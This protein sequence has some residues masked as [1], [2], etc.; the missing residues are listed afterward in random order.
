MMC[1]D[2]RDGR[3]RFL[4]LLCNCLVTFGSYYCFDMPGVLQAQFQG[5]L[6][7]SDEQNAKNASVLDGGGG[8]ETPSGLGLTPSKYNLLYA[9][10]AWGNVV[11]VIPF[12][13]LMDKIG[14]RVSVMLFSSFCVLGSLLFALSVRLRDSTH[15]MLALMLAGRVLFGCGNVSLIIVQFRIVAFWFREKELAMAFGVTIAFSR[16][17]SVL[18][19]LC[20]E[21]FEH[22]FGLEA[23]LW[24]GAVLCAVSLVAACTVGYLDQ[25]GL[26][27]LGLYAGLRREAKSVNI[28]DVRRFKR[29]YWMLVLTTVCFYS[30]IFPFI[31]N[32]SKFIQDMYEGFSQ[33]QAS[34]VVGAT[35][36]VSMVLCAASGVLVDRV[37]QRG[38]MISAAAA[39]T[40][41]VFPVLAYGGLPPLAST[42]WL[43]VAY[44]VSTACM[45]PAISM[46]VPYSTLGTANGVATSLQML[47]VGVSNLAVG[48][49]LGEETGEIAP[50]RWQNVMF[51]FLALT[52]GCLASSLVLNVVDQ[53]AGQIINRSRVRQAA[54]RVS[55]EAPLLT[56]G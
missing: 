37:G 2:A 16:L 9:V 45:W 40:L 24:A 25:R 28:T 14:N 1:I 31:A 41:P 10:Y 55:E 53:D 4:V 56:D 23:T 30:T 21:S 47:G 22:R 17:G 29:T 51:Y 33:E 19:F 48:V 11:L 7:C 32:G 49:L 50:W 18:N 8:C 42:L 34:L 46:V 38:F 5:N 13:Y 44:S 12:G 52:L 26:Q 6:N 3:Y 27:Q 35:Y 54:D 20:T 36:M 43:G 39:S 15:S